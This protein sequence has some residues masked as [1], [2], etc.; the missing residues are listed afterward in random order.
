MRDAD[1]VIHRVQV[2]PIQPL[3]DADLEILAGPT[4]GDGEDGHADPPRRQP[5][6]Q[7]RLVAVTEQHI[8]PLAGQQVGQFG[9]GR[10]QSRCV[11]LE[12]LGGETSLPR[13]LDERGAAAPLREADEAAVPAG[14][15]SGG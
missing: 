6:Q 12:G 5:P 9:D 3:V 7:V 11:V 1:D 2:Q 15:Q 13:L 8:G 10:G 14:G 4:A